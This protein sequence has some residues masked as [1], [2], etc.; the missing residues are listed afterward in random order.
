MLL[1]EVKL[2]LQTIHSRLLLTFILHNALTVICP[3]IPQTAKGWIIFCRPGI[4]G[5]PKAEKMVKGWNITVYSCGNWKYVSVL[6]FK[7]PKAEKLLCIH[8]VAWVTTITISL[9]KLLYIHVPYLFHFKHVLTF[10]SYTPQMANEKSKLHL[11]W[12]YTP[13]S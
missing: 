11:K 10:N 8:V 6:H 13:L 12:R 4:H 2:F 5:L 9:L 7:W 3:Y 1:L